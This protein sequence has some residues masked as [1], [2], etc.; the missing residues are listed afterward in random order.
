MPHVTLI[1]HVFAYF[2][3]LI[4]NPLRIEQLSKTQCLYHFGV[5]KVLWSYAQRQY[6][7]Q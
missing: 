5:S 2:G 1:Y 3:Q 4:S 6:Y 7:E